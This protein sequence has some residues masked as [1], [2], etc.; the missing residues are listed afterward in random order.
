ME[1]VADVISVE[2]VVSARDE[3]VAADVNEEA[4]KAD[5]DLGALLL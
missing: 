3:K 1:A 5:V 2:G 4:R